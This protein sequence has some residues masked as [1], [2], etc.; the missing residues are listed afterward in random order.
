MSVV[1]PL[2]SSPHESLSMAIPSSSPDRRTVLTRAGAALTASALAGVAGAPAAHAATSDPY[3]PSYGD[4]RYRVSH[5]D[6]G[7]TVIVN[8]YSTHVSGATTMRATA[9]TALT[10]LEIDFALRPQR[11]IINGADVRWT[12]LSWRKIRVTG[13]R[14]AAG[15][16]FTLTVRY[17]D[18]PVQRWQAAGVHDGVLN[19]GSLVGFFGQPN[20]APFWYAS[21]DRLTNK[22]TYALSVSTQRGNKIAASGV[23]TSQFDFMLG[24]RAMSNAKY[25]VTQPVQ[26][27]APMLAVGRMNQRFGTWSGPNGERVPTTFSSDTWTTDAVVSHTHQSMTYFSRLY[28]A[29]PFSASGA[30]TPSWNFDLLALE[31]VGAPV[32]A[33]AMLGGVTPYIV[34]H[35]QAHMWFGNSVTAASWKDVAFFHEGLATL[36]AAD[37]CAAYATGNTVGYS[38]SATAANPGAA[39]LFSNDSYLSA[40]GIMREL[41]REMDGSYAQARAPRFTAM[42]RGIA[43]DFRYGS[44]TRAQFKARAA[45]AAGRDLSAFWRRYGL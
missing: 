44:I 6:I 12:I 40:H 23:R 27:W 7:D 5:Y 15:A 31:T 18:Y 29:F 42:L 14:L 11:I 8:G 17:G 34:A 3:F 28:G 25:S 32:Y 36:L 4:S 39:N 9:L 22:A 1:I 41:R 13:F 16:P 10:D 2:N 37:Y 35:E 45:A 43:R 26:S 21:N 38:W 20:G 24:T 19:G 30:L 33:P